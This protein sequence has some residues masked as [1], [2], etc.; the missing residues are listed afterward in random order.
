VLGGRGEFKGDSGGNR[1]DE[2]SRRR[3]DGWVA[4]TRAGRAQNAEF[5]WSENFLRPGPYSW[6]KLAALFT[7]GESPKP[8]SRSAEVP[9]RCC[10]A[11]A[12]RAAPAS[13]A[14]LPPCTSPSA[15]A[16]SRPSRRH[17][18]SGRTRW[19]T[20]TSLASCFPRR[21]AHVPPYRAPTLSSSPV[22]RRTRSRAPHRLA[23]AAPPLRSAPLC[24]ALRALVPAR[25][26]RSSSSPPHPS[27]DPTP[28]RN[29][30]NVLLNYLVLMGQMNRAR[31]V[32]K[33]AYENK[34]FAK[35][36]VFDQHIA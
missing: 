7:D 18:P 17:R 27:R 2:R 24:R 16:V 34:L 26:P 10:S 1:R 14:S 22:P 4:A 32:W 9:R 33:V 13:A 19:I 12:S 3:M 28:P 21:L 31:C 5:T 8:P 30:V 11:S 20:W 23:G 29:F 35:A 25:P 36:I 6:Y 15:A